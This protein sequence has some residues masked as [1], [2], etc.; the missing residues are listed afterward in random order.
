MLHLMKDG[1]LWRNK[2]GQGVWHK[3]SDG[4]NLAGPVCRDSCRGPYVPGEEGPP[5]NIRRA[6]VT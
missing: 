1:Q 3:C 2:I 5:L 4:G 6:S